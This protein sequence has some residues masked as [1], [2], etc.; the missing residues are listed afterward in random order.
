MAKRIKK[1]ESGS[2]MDG[3]NME[4]TKPNI[5]RVRLNSANAPEYPPKVSLGSKRLDW[6]KKKNTPTGKGGSG[7][8]NAVGNFGAAIEKEDGGGGDGAFGDG[9]GTVFTST[10]AGIFT[11]THGDS[12]TRR[13]KSKKKRSGIE[14]LGVFL[15]DG[16]PE[17][18]MKK[19]ATVLKDW[20]EKQQE[21]E[22]AH[23]PQFIEEGEEEEDTSNR[24]V[25]EQLDMENKIAM[26]NDEEKKKEDDN[27]PSADIASAHITD[28]QLAKQP[29][30]F[31]NPQDDELMRGGKKDKERETEMELEISS[32]LKDLGIVSKSI[33]KEEPLLDLMKSED[34]TLVVQHL[35][36]V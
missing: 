1:I 15:T 9:G 20:V 2:N 34:M 28:V 4:G 31:G 11:P 32:F 29:M 17:K 23:P 24:V 12:K 18:K 16:S 21:E 13:V 8:A 5:K 14:R 22:E 33:K 36:R 10:N 27:K 30:A 19:K 26:I 7:S 35:M 6:G 3:A 25:A